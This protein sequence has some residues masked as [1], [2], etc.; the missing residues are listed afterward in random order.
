M[1]SRN[2]GRGCCWSFISFMFADSAEVIEIQVVDT[3]SDIS[4]IFPT[5]EY[6]EG[7]AVIIPDVVRYVWPMLECDEVVASPEYDVS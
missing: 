6:V 5:V 4:S 2:A 1:L 7:G 3:D